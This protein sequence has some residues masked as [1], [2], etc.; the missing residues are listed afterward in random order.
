MFNLV[1]FTKSP[2]YENEIEDFIEVNCIGFEDV[3]TNK[4][5]H[6]DIH[7]KYI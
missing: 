6:F 3:E 4:H 7:Q 5:E 1:T 2:Y